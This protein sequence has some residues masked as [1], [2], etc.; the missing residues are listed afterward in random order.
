MKAIVWFAVGLVLLVGL[1]VAATSDDTMTIDI[2]V[3]PSTLLLGVSQSGL[4]NV[5]TDIDYS[6][7][8]RSS[9]QLEGIPL[10]RSKA[11]ACGNF[12]GFFDEA[13]VKALVAA[14]KATLTM[15]GVTNDGTGFVGWDT[16][17]VKKAR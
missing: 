12:V 17:V 1:A 8:N 6:A 16:V 5:H 14:P 15:V 7:V 9:V 4:V 2:V 11:D 13:K 10:T 3:A